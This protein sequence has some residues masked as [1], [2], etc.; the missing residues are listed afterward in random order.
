VQQA[1]ARLGGDQAG[2]GPGAAHVG[3]VAP[4]GS[5]AERAH[6]PRATTVAGGEHRVRVTDRV[7]GLG[8]GKVHAAQRTRGGRDQ[9]P[10][11][12]AVGGAID[13]PTGRLGGHR[14]ARLRAGEDDVGGLCATTAGS[15]RARDRRA[16]GERPPGVGGAQDRAVLEQDVARVAG[17]E[18]ERLDLRGAAV[19]ARGIVG[20]QQ[21]AEGAGRIAAGTDQ[22]ERTQ[23]VGLRNRVAREPPRVPDADRG[24]RG[25]G[26][27]EGSGAG[28]RHRPGGEG[29]P[30]QRVPVLGRAT[31]ALEMLVHRY[32]PPDRPCECPV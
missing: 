10:R 15:A 18:V 6:G 24:G 19:V 9:R 21:R 13:A 12:G 20:A 2:V 8:G 30:S 4:G 22:L 26:E 25:R 17:R 31:A 11:A 3:Q 27:R 7:A 23:V 28:K 29:R 1:I 32:R 14:E 5:A 16:L